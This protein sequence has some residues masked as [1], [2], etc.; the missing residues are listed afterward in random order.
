MEFVTFGGSSWQ[1]DTINHSNLLMEC[2][3]AMDM[4]DVR[5]GSDSDIKDVNSET[6]NVTYGTYDLVLEGGDATETSTTDFGTYDLGG[7]EAADTPD[8]KSDSGSSVVEHDTEGIENDTSEFGMYDFAN[9]IFTRG[10]ADLKKKPKKRGRKPKS[11]AMEDAPRYD[12]GDKDYIASSSNEYSN[13]LAEQKELESH[14]ELIEA[15]Q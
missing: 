14:V 2:I 8:A 10:G 13:T 5:G 6:S 11:I 15:F 3:A 9:Q 4:D 1:S 7:G 12:V